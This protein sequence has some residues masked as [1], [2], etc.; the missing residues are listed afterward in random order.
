MN[1]EFTDRINREFYNFL[2]ENNFEIVKIK[3]N[4]DT[5]VYTI[6]DENGVII[7]K[8]QVVNSN[9]SANKLIDLFL[10]FYE[11]KIKNM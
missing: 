10:D 1:N 6:K 8:F 4:F 3:H 11:S 9:K 7:E 5:T 2:I